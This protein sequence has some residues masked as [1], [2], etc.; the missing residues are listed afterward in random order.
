MPTISTLEEIKLNDLLETA[1]STEWGVDDVAADPLV[2]S[3]ITQCHVSLEDDLVKRAPLAE[4]D[5]VMAS[6]WKWGE[7]RIGETSLVRTRNITAKNSSLPTFTVLEVVGE[8]MPFL[9]GSILGACRESNLHAEMVLHPIIDHSRDEKG[10][11]VQLTG[12]TR[13]SYIQVFLQ[14]L[15][16][17]SRVE[18]EAEVKKTL[19]DIRNCV[20]DFATLQARM[21]DSASIVGMNSF[22]DNQRAKEA[23]DFL[24]W[25]ANDH[26]TF[27]GSRRYTFARDENGELK[28]EEPEIVP[29]SSLGIL[30]NESNFILKR[31]SEPTIITGR[32]SEF[33]NEPDP[34]IV[35]KAT[36]KSRVHRRVSAD[37]VGIKQYDDTGKVV[38]ETRFVG[39]FTADAYNAMTKDVPLIREKVRRVLIAAGKRPN[40]HDSNALR[41]IL[42]TYP[43]DELFQIEDGELLANA[44]GILKLQNQTE[45]RI[46]VRKDR[47]D[48]YLSALVYLPKESFHSELRQKIGHTLET[49]FGGTLTAF[50][51]HYGDGPLARVHF[52]LDLEPGHPEPETDALEAEIAE[53]ARSWNDDLRA[54]IRS[55]RSGL[56]KWIHPEVVAGAFSPGYK[57][58]FSAH[59]ALTDLMT[60]DHLRDGR[61]VSLRAL[62]K[63]GDGP[64]TIRAKIYTNDMPVQLSESVPVFES[65]GLFV[66]SESSFAVQPNTGM[67]GNYWVHSLS[68]RSSDGKDIAFDEIR[69][70]FEDAFEAVWTQKTESDGFNRLV[71][72]IG[73][74][75]R[76]S[77]LFRT[78]S[79]YRKQTGM[80]LAQSTQI[81]ALANNPKIA[82]LLLECFE[83][84]FNPELDLTLEERADKCSEITKKIS[85][86]L[87][88]VDSLDEDRV[89]QRLSELIHAIKRTSFYQKRPDD[90]PLD[91][92]AIKIASREIEALPEPRPFR[93]I[94]MCAPH[95]EGVHLRFGPVARG[96]LRWSDRRDD[97]RTEVLGLVKAQQVKNSVIVPVGS[98]GGFF[99]KQLPKNGTRDEITTEAIR[100]YKTFIRSLLSLTD[101]LIDGEPRHPRN[102]VIWDGSDPYLVVAADKGTATFSDIANEISESYD[103][104]LGDAFASGGSAGYDHKKMGITARGAWVAVQRHFREIDVDIQSER[105]SVIGVGDMSGDVFGNGMLLSKKIMLKAAFNHMHIFIDPAPQDVEAAWHE[106]NRMFELPRSTWDDYDKSL[107]SEGGGVFPRSAKRIELTPQIKEFI[108]VEDD[109]LTP[110]E[111][112]QAI[113]KAEADL[114]WFG[115]IGT[116]VKS[117][118]ET[119]MQVGDKANDA[120]RI[121]ADELNVKV[122]GEGANLGVTQ[123]GRI[124]FAR[125]GGRINTD[126]VD[127]SAGVD[128]SDHEVNIKILLR[129]AIDSGD[130]AAGDRNE[131]LASMTKEVAN[132]VLIHNY[133]QT[134]ALSVAEASAAHDLD[135]HERMMER[136]EGAGLLKRAVEGLPKA[137][138]IRLLHDQHQGLTRPELSVLLAYAKITLFDELI[139]SNVP[140]DAFLSD[141]F[142]SYFPDEL[143]QFESAMENHR[144][145]REIIATQLAN[146]IINLG[147]IT[148][149]HRVKER[150]GVETDQTARAFIAALSIFSLR[151]LL[152]R[153]DELDNQ[154]PANVQIRLRVDLISALRRQVF[155]LAKTRSINGEIGDLVSAYEDGVTQLVAANTDTLSPYENGLLEETK[156]EYRDIGAPSDV[157]D[158][159]AVILSMTSATDIVDLSHRTGRDVPKMATLFNAIGDKFGYERIRQTALSL[160]LDQHW[161]RLAVRGI[162]ETLVDQQIVLAERISANSELKDWDDFESA[163]KRVDG[164]V[165]MHAEDHERL[166]LN[167]AE[168]EHSGAWTF[169]KL[170]LFANAMRSFIDD[171]DVGAT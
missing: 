169:A 60:I 21:R 139:D 157:S 40:S 91:Y 125:K 92:I 24:T 164:F 155:W 124:E 122:V 7:T 59:E 147:G 168:L 118:A 72:A 9:V 146:D 84:R 103:F 34:L 142:H 117:H 57:D 64:D 89:L 43:R 29:G 145:K 108:G 74:D 20:A 67:G 17:E 55:R 13:E 19:S 167:L 76:E 94:F 154:V 98:K 26:F 150:A 77:A 161:D 136:L 14:L 28:P 54:L 50:Y 96:G 49:A 160:K 163:R 99:P 93:E 156:A 75:W 85:E 82:T 140:D 141:Q 116:Y 37:Y 126:A 80:D 53:L 27:L 87:E 107:I 130:L 104:W 32:I 73:A 2:R 121:S 143:L 52:M 102:T 132:K 105:F 51:P 66:V 151:P 69:N 58:M 115:G 42:E 162:V 165:A 158:R 12:D 97:F 70:K 46:F 38:G 119:D 86:A 63:V 48:R 110:N 25:L 8:D 56:P 71:L 79:R 113:L 123:A 22:L 171:T 101:N 81:Q 45:T 138:D 39:L 166:E 170:V 78:L 152:K 36:L 5:K 3:F 137:E 4:L 41:H 35:A 134:G 95:V 135:S 6:F 149:V 131:L 31:G 88:D 10:H 144:L 1:T 16:D 15:D 127:N 61:T 129:N 18:L 133:D 114:L 23:E 148:F 106:R 30:R 33:L 109:V 120:I 44:N 47:F 153:I 111:L 159:V 11:R 83:A 128:S 65:M 68:M 62:R 90:Q 112:I 100:S